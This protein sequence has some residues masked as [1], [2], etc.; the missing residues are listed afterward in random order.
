MTIESAADLAVFTSVA[1][2]G[3]VASYTPKSGG[4]SR[5][6]SG[7]FDAAYVDVSVGLDQGFGSVGPRILVAT[8]ALTNGGREG[9]TWVI[10]GITYKATMSEPDGTGM[11]NVK[12]EKQ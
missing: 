8:T 5:S 10:S 7:I 2:F 3:L 11:T 9:D 12:L 4:A 1:D 6:V